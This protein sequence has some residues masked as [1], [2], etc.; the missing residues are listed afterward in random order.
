MRGRNPIADSVAGMLLE[1]SRYASPPIAGEGQLTPRSPFA[2]PAL[3][4]L[5]GSAPAAEPPR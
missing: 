5:G 3:Q 2:A 1:A 4:Q